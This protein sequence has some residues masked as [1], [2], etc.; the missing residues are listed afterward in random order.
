MENPDAAASMQP[1]APFSKFCQPPDLS[2]R[3]A[4]AFFAISERFFFVS[5][6]ARAFPPLLP[7]SAAADFMA[8]FSVTSPV[9]SLATIIAAPIASAG[10]R[11]PLGPFGTDGT[12]AARKLALCLL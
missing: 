9:A 5:A 12:L 10:R 7:S 4:A 3:F 2:H 1:Y 8:A 11:S 6:A